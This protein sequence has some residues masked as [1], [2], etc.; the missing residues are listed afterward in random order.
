MR[1]NHPIAFCD[2]NK[3]QGAT[4]AEAL[5]NTRVAIVEYL[6]AVDDQLRGEDIRVVA[7]AAWLCQSF[8]ASITW[9]LSDA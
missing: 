8:P 6:S 3:S 4:E 1:A 2:A 9:L 5:E 7:V